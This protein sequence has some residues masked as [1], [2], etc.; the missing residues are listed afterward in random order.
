MTEHTIGKICFISPEEREIYT[1][2]FA[3][4]AKKTG[5]IK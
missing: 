1:K 2:R 5:E 3:E 4:A